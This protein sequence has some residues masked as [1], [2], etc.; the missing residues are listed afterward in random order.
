MKLLALP[1]ILLPRPPACLAGFS[2]SAAAAVLVVYAA[3]VSADVCNASANRDPASGILIAFA[4][5]VVCIRVRC[6]VAFAGESQLPPLS[7]LPRVCV[8][9]VDAYARA[10]A[11]GCEVGRVGESLDGA[12]ASL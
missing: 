10:R 4:A 2:C 5:D 7:G 1:D 9:C 6:S 8:L 12:G 11:S 3:R